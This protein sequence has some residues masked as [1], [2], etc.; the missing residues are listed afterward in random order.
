[1]TDPAGR[2]GGLLVVTAVDA[3]RDALAAGLRAA[4]HPARLLDPRR[5]DRTGPDG[6]ARVDLAAARVDLAAVGVGPA[7]A[8]AGT[9]RLL[10]WAQATGPAYRAVVCAGIGGGFPGRAGVG[11]LIVATRAVA[12]DLGA[13]SPDG[14]IPVQRLGFGTG[15]VPVPPALHAALLA[16]L[17]GAVAGEVLTVSTVTGTAEGT[18]VLR[19]RHPD[20]AG[21]AMEGFGAA[22]AAAGADVDFAEVRAVSNLIGPRDR[23]AWRIGAALEALGTLGAVLGTLAW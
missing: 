10:A 3:E 18:A 11:E 9:A 17:P 14:F 21:E 7:A 5:P 8:A 12:A 20:A 2:P 4:G 15:A 13:D 19:R 6:A 16:A 1:V 23:S 22:A